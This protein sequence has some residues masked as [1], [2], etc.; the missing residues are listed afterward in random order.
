MED[1]N[2]TPKDLR[3]AYDRAEARATEAELAAKT[4]KDELRQFQAQVTF[5][6]Q[7]LTP[8]HA[9]LFLKTN[10]DAEVTQDAVHAFVEEYGLAPAPAAVPAEDAPATPAGIPQLNA[11]QEAGG[12]GTQGSAPAA[13]PKMSKADFQKLLETNPQEAAK[14]YVEGRTERNELNVV[15]RDLVAK[16]II[17][18]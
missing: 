14:A 3:E 18:H 1:E 9:D 16:G 10:P 7:G 13:A 5:E 4:A 11:F 8:K 17:D 6:K 2:T 15:A 12:S